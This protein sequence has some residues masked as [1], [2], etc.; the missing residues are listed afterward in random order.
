MLLQIEKILVEMEGIV[1]LDYADQDL[2]RLR[3]LHHKAKAKLE[4]L[5]FGLHND[6]N[7]ILRLKRR[8]A[9]IEEEFETHD[10]INESMWNL[11]HNKKRPK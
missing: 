6:T 7:G 9:N 10:D 11:L 4:E 1:E 5:E 2:E 3:D 8:M